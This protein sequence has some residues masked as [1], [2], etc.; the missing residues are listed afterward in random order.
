MSFNLI[1]VDL[2]I[3]INTQKKD[4]ATGAILL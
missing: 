1:C 4:F 3:D 2:I